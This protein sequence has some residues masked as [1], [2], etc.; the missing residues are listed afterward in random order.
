MSCYEIAS[1]IVKFIISLSTQ[2]ENCHEMIQFSHH[3]ISV[4]KPETR[5]LLNFAGR[6]VQYR[7]SSSFCANHKSELVSGFLVWRFAF[8]PH[9]LGYFFS[10][11]TKPSTDSSQPFRSAILAVFNVATHFAS[12][13]RHHRGSHL[14]QLGPRQVSHLK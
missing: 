1:S 3:S 8:G 12:R 5:I 14:S 4:L 13:L 2:C 10:N 11:R 9:T 6:V 7:C